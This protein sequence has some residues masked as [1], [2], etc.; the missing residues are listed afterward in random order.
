MIIEFI[1][2]TVPAWPRREDPDYPIRAAALDEDA[3]FDKLLVGYGASAPAG[4]IVANEML[5]ATSRIGM[6][7]THVPGLVAPALAARQFATLAAFHHGRVSLHASTEPGAAGP[8]DG[9]ACE[10]ALWPRRAAEF[11]DIVRL[12]WHSPE[13]FDYCGEFYQVAGSGAAV[14]S[15]GAGSRS[16]SPPSLPTPCEPAPARRMSSSSRV[17]R[18]P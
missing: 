13:P 9:D 17:R 18:R 4:L 14:S 5:T 15:A 16:T 11:L 1:G 2:S 7:I 8:R 10:P 6:L 12:S 3:G